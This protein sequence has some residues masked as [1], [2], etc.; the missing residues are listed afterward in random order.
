MKNMKWI[1]SRDKF[2]NE[3][4]IRDV[5]FKKQAEKVKR[6]WGEKFLDYEEVTPTDKIKQGKW[7][8]DNEDKIRV[9]GKFFDA[10]MDNVFSLFKDIPDKFVDIIIK[11]IN[12]ELFR[13]EEKEKY[14]RTF[15]DFNIKEP[16]IG[17]IVSIFDNVFRKLNTNETIATEMIQKDENGRPVRDEDG[18]MVKIKKEA[19]EP[20][21]T[22]NLININ[23]F[24]DDYNRCFPDLKVSTSIF[25]DSDL[26]SIRNLAAEDHNGE[27]EVDFDIFGKDLYLSISHNPKDIL[28]MSISKFYSSCQH[29]Y[30]GGYNDRV[31][32]NVFDPNSIPAFLVFDTPIFW[33]EERIS[34]QLPLTRM[35]IRNMEGYDGRQE[36]KIFFDRAYPDRMKDIFG[37]IVEKYTGMKDSKDESESYLFTPDIDPS[38]DV[39]EPYMDRLSLK[40]GKL[41]GIN[42]KTLYLSRISDW[43]SYKISK[44]AKIR[45]L[46]VETTD[47]PENLFTIDLN[48]DWIK[49]KF[50]KI[51]TLNNFEKLKSN[52]I[53]FDK[54]K[55]DGSV[56]DSIK[57]ANPG[58]NKLSIIACDV[59]NL[60]LSKF[61]QLEELQL[62]YTIERGTK[63]QDVMN[64]VTTKKLVVSGD[65]VSDKETKSYL[66]SLKSRG[67]KVEIVGP[68]I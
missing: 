31:L 8:L 53:A 48:L 33:D 24:V 51:K 62:V 6:M 30:S 60:D 32:G 15:K 25:N 37:E 45:E 23:S 68:V 19:G 65:L 4:K 56:L 28:N 66:N 13:G 29:L 36:A 61:G 52:S 14:E 1:K 26:R 7:K 59:N 54:C 67:V 18:Q 17:Q 20:I 3:A 43:S 10:D 42:T 2:L 5:I 64:G 22:N 27:Y 12:Y 40:R 63:L 38:D 9:L 44:N 55:F 46:I 49:F 58:L 11:S 35:V 41:I 47:I 21:F 39:R 57:E 34:D 16:S 50:L